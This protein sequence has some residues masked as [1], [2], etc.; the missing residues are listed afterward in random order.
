MSWNVLIDGYNVLLNWPQFSRDLEMD[1]NLARD[2]LLHMAADFAHY[3]GHRVIVVFDAPN[4]DLP[5]TTRKKT[6][7]IEVVFT[8]KDQTADEY[9]IEW[10]R[11]YK[12]E[13]HVEVITSDGELSRAARRQGASVRSVLEFSDSYARTKGGFRFSR[14][15]DAI[16]D[17][18]PQL[19]DWIDPKMRR[20]LEQLKRR[21]K[22]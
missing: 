16:P 22:K 12:G 15:Q 19:G 7:G 13:A 8:K 17:S 1:F 10:L 18:D 3:H 5:R 21:L 2:R 20:Q 14:P 11:R 4:R 6:H 9:I